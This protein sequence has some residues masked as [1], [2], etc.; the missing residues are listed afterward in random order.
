MIHLPELKS[1]FRTNG[2]F[3]QEGVLSPD[4]VQTLTAWTESFLGH[5]SPAGVRNLLD[6]EAVRAL[7]RHPSIRKLA[8][9]LL[10]EGAFAVR[11]ILFDK[12]PEKN[13]VVPYHQDV[14]IAVKNRAEAEGFKTF[15]VKDGVLHVR[16]PAWVL[17]SMATLR[18][19]LDPCGPDNGPVRILPRTHRNGLL[20]KDAVKHLQEVREEVLCTCDAGGVLAMSPL[21]L[22]ASSKA[23]KPG[24]RR[25][26]HIE[27]AAFDLPG[28]LEWHDRV[29]VLD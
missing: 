14:S 5:R 20:D 9:T 12:N 23:S 8:T 15:S 24:H 26:I 29:R 22:H 6:E 1:Q 7:V 25:V 13:W 28:G 10:G 18:I 3:I 4:E 2:F 17:E 27:F 16:P 19:H 21:I 11:A